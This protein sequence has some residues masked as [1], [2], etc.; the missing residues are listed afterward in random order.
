MVGLR[1]RDLFAS[2]LLLFALCCLPVSVRAQQSCTVPSQIPVAPGQNLFTPAQESDLGDVI[3]EQFQKK[4]LVIEDEALNLEMSRVT[5]RLL[6]QIPPTGLRVQVFLV[7]SPAVDAFSLPG[8]RIYVS[9]KLVA[10]VR[11]EDEIAGVLAHEIGHII[12]HQGAVTVSRI[13]RE[14]LGANSVTDRAD[15]FAKYDSLLDSDPRKQQKILNIKNE[16]QLNQYQADQVAL[17][18]LG[19]AGYSPTSFAAFFDRL[20]ETKGKAGSWFTNV[21]GFTT[22]D[23]KRLAE[24]RKG[25]ALIPAACREIAVHP[26]S[27]EFKSWQDAVLGYSGLGRKDVL[28]GL[29]AK[30]PLNSGLRNELSRLIFSPDGRHVLAQD[31]SSV[32]VITVSP[33]EFKFRIDAP[34][35]YPAKFTPDGE[36]LVFADHDY[37]VEKWSIADE[38]RSG[39]HDVPIRDGC[40]QT[41]LSPDGRLLAC[42]DAEAGLQL[43]DAETGAQIFEK[44]LAFAPQSLFEQFLWYFTALRTEGVNWVAMQFSPDARY[45]V[46]ARGDRSLAFDAGTHAAFPLKGALRAHLGFGFT[47]V[48]ADKILGVDGSNLA[49]SVVAGFPSG[50]VLTNVNVGQSALHQTGCPGYALI[51]PIKDHAAG[52]FSVESKSI[53]LASERVGLDACNGVSVNE[54]ADSSLALTRLDDD[55]IVGT[56]Q[57]PQSSLVNLR[58][59]SASPDLRWLA[60]SS[61][62]RGAIWDLNSGNRLLSTRGFRGAY[63]DANSMLFAD[64][65]SYRD[66]ERT[67]TKTNLQTNQVSSLYKIPKAE[68]SDQFGRFRIARK[69]SEKNPNYLV[70]LTFEVRD[71][72]DD[73]VL[74]SQNFPRN[75][76]QLSVDLDGNDLLFWWRADSDSGKDILNAHPELKSRLNAPENKSEFLIEIRELASGKTLGDLVVGSPNRA[77]TVRSTFAIGD[78]VGIVDGENRTVL[79]SLSTGARI[80]SVFGSRSALSLNPAL[81]VI[82][83]QPGHMQVYSLP[84]FEKIVEQTFS[85]PLAYAHFS[86]DGHQLV[87]ITANQTAY[88]FDTAFKSAS[89]ASH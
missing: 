59:A 86:Q 27:N 53:F 85:S 25:M 74:W 15:I 26:A 2:G 33:F 13:F 55:K 12:T 21:F 89:A 35:A 22:P 68:V 36:S 7:D 48:A 18:I 38:S 80:G 82:E 64:F 51:T 34:Q 39:I 42:L 16:E 9:R 4:F 3:T 81:L 66:M 37:R 24:M 77:F 49:K 1:S 40:I 71:I 83:N 67:L 11:N 63:F 8:G 52:L 43:F 76:P 6:A 69:R 79:Y 87:V 44:K 58:V 56:L 75:A 28:Q 29:I 45:F 19:S 47:F 41:Q 23:Q 78:W 54:R 32:Y 70:N 88:F 14:V 61:S 57:L 17:E 31:E 60:V 20:A 84:S 50:D 5:G 46:A 30:R 10:F 73:T 62:T 65:P 72:R